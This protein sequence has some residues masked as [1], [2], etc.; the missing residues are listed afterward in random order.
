MKEIGIR[1]D[2]DEMRFG[3]HIDIGIIEVCTS[4]N[5][6]PEMREALFRWKEWIVGY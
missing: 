3:H 5:W 2:I 6:V 1:S 4:Y